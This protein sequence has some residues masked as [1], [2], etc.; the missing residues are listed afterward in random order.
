MELFPLNLLTLKSPLVQQQTLILMLSQAENNWH[1]QKKELPWK[2]T[3]LLGIQDPD[4]LAEQQME[5]EQ[6]Y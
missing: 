2:K 5:K 6:I 3:Q 4:F 1:G